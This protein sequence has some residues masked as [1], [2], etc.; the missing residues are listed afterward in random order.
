MVF[1]LLFTFFFL[2]S[3]LIER[4]CFW[5]L[6]SSV[7]SVDGS[8]GSALCV[9][10]AMNSDDFALQCDDLDAEEL[11]RLVKKLWME[12]EELRIDLERTR[13]ERD[14]ALAGK[15]QSVGEDAG[16]SDRAAAFASVVQPGRRRSRS[17]QEKKLVV[18]EG[19][20]EAKLALKF[21][22]LD[23]SDVVILSKN[24][25][26]NPAL[27]YPPAID[28]DDLSGLCNLLRENRLDVTSLNLRSLR[29]KGI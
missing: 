29:S 20:P 17:G 26:V 24:D 11:K 22:H 19:T 2:F 15:P 13:R 3:A 1:F 25:P 14:D 6:L 21:P 23:W 7:I 5:F 10:R 4:V 12:K 9:L 16:L 8:V 27:S 28:D 18:A